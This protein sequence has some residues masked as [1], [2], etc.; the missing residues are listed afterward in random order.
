VKQFLLIASL[1]LMFASCKNAQTSVEQ[2]HTNTQTEII[3]RD[4]VFVLAPDFA[5]FKAK[6]ETKADGSLK[7]VDETSKA[8]KRINAPKVKIEGNQISV[9]CTSEAQRLFHQWKEKHT[10]QQN[11]KVIHVPVAANLTDW[12][13]FQIWTGRITLIALIILLILALVGFFVQRRNLK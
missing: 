7:L 2:N 6:I 10:R 9:D 3:I 4:T 8:G 1:G 11:T 5:T 12:Q 13:N